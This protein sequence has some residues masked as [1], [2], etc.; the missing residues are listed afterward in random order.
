M[1]KISIYLLTL[2]CFE[3]LIESL[4]FLEN[5]WRKAKEQIRLNKS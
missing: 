5:L 2:L 1:A 3:T 4:C